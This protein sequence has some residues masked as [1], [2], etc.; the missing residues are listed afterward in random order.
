LN[1]GIYL[2]TSGFLTQQKR[3][4]IIANNLAN[5]NTAGYK[6]DMPVFKTQN[7]SRTEFLPERGQPPWTPDFVSFGGQ[8][9]DFSQGPLTR[10]GNPLDIALAGDG[11]FEVQSPRGVRYSR[12]GDFVLA[13]DGTLVTQG[14][15]PVIGEG[16][17]IVLT[18]GKIEIDRDG[19]VFVDS[20]Q[21]GKLHIVTFPN[22][23]K[24][25]KEG[26]AL[27]AWVGKASE[28]KPTDQAEVMS[29]YLENSNVNPI[30]EMVHMIEAIRTYEVQQKVIHSF[31]S[32]RKKAVD[33]VGRLR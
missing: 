28:V 8:A 15:D 22:T 21:H 6:G 1:H 16:G 13:D 11:F 30:K 5:A 9:T 4:E 14:G 18:Q 17:A 12:K 29:G 26:E 27:F 19:T 23:E 32:T 25:V 24:L 20:N 3:L 10:T 2:A 33:E 7:P 31:D